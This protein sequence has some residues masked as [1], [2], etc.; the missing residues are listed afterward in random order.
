[1]RVPMV[2]YASF[3]FPISGI[4]GVDVQEKMERKGSK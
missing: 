3:R 2:G 1:V 4:I